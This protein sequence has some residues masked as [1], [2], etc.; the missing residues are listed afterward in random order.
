MERKLYGDMIIPEFKLLKGDCL[1]TLK[2]LED[3]SIDAVLC[4]PPYHLQSI[5]KRFSAEDAKESQYGKDGLFQRASKG[6]MGKSWDGG[7]I[8][9]R[10][11]VWRE[12]YRVLK[13]GGHLVAFGGTRTIHRITCAIE[14]SGFEIRDMISWLYFSGFPKSHDVSKGID[15]HLGAEREVVGDY[16][17]RESWGKDFVGGTGYEDTSINITK[18]ATP[19]AAQWEGWGTALK[20]SYE[21]AILARK[22]LEKGLTVAQNV[23]K[24]GTGGLNIDKSRFRYGDSCWV[25]PNEKDISIGSGKI[26]YG[27]QCR[28]L[29]PGTIN[30]YGRWPANI[31]QCPKPSRA[32]KEAGLEHLPSITGAEATGREEGS[33]GLTPRAGAGRSAAEIRNTHPTVKPVRLFSWL[34]NL[35]CRP[36]GI[37]LDPFLGSGTTAVAGILEG[38]DIVGCELTPEYWPIIEGRVS[39]AYDAWK[40]KHRQYKLF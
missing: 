24:W 35:I 25:G 27:S 28:G 9:F 39:W 17:K 34:A 8:A 37:I 29:N 12:C 32:E 21:P 10:T 11:D 2:Q 20:P 6:F 23:L 7:D 22:P 36:G 15:R 4:D 1:E 16:Q 30:P 19:Q 3:N 18:P 31:Y 26:G 38:F 5:V 14:D 33:A 13:P 40:D